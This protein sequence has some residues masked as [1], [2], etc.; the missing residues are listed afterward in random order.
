MT[1]TAEAFPEERRKRNQFALSPQP[2]GVAQ[3]SRERGQG[4]AVLALLYPGPAR[5][6]V[7]F[8]EGAG[9]GAA[10][11]LRSRGAAG[12]AP[13]EAQGGVRC[14]ISLGAGENSHFLCQLRAPVPGASS[15]VPPPPG[16]AEGA[17][18]GPQPP[19]LGVVDPC[20]L[21]HHGVFALLILPLSKPGLAGS[22]VTL[23]SKGKPALPGLFAW[24]IFLPC[25]PRR[26]WRYGHPSSPPPFP[27]SRRGWNS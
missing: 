12:A 25:N 19:R 16:L 3:R 20:P 4:R 10:R 17:G 7:T 23:P 5:G 24:P 8:P 18:M 27:P 21:H 11:W 22:S 1:A 26:G 9:P 13:G 6:M 14:V 15:S 2:R